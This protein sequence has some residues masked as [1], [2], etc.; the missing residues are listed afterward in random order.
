LHFGALGHTLG[1]VGG[2]LALDSADHKP[3]EAGACQELLD[4]SLSRVV[5]EGSFDRRL[6]V[7]AR[8]ACSATRSTTWR[9]TT[10]RTTASGSGP[11]KAWSTARSSCGEA[12]TSPAAAWS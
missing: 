9:S 8:D 7:G 5:L 11:A 1:E 3:L 12:S 4:E 2:K 6:D 10:E